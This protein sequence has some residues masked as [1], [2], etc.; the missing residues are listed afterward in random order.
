MKDKKNPVFITYFNPKGLFNHQGT[1][2]DMIGVA[3][4]LQEN[5]KVSHGL[6]IKSI[7][8]K[9]DRKG[10]SDRAIGRAFSKTPCIEYV[11]GD[12]IAQNLIEKEKPLLKFLH[13]KFVEAVKQDPDKFIQLQAEMRK[14]Q[15]AMV[16]GV[17]VGT[18]VQP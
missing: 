7:L 2:L 1:R 18:P 14:K 4:V 8:D 9:M 17:A 16:A 3:T 6:S 15:L 5:G 10:G 13:K 12:E 11:A